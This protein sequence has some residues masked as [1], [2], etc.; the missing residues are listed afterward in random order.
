[1]V[2]IAGG[3]VAVGSVLLL[4]NHAHSAV[5]RVIAVRFSVL[6]RGR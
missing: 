1:M 6:L 3:G 2:F 5:L 4:G